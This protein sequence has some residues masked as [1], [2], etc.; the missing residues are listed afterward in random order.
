[1]ENTL[2]DFLEQYGDIKSCCDG[3][4]TAM[5]DGDIV[6]SDGERLGSWVR[7]KCAEY[8]GSHCLGTISVCEECGE[9]VPPGDLVGGV[10]IF[11]R[12]KEN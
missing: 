1:M 6:W 4:Y 8:D 2:K 5:D 9:T 11:C 10:C 7:Y 12:H 3:T